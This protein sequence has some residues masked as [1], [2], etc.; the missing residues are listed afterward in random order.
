[1]IF[2]AT[3]ILLHV[4]AAAVS[5]SSD[6]EEIIL[7]IAEASSTHHIVLSSTS[8]LGGRVSM[9]AVRKNVFVIIFFLLYV[10]YNLMKPIWS[11]LVRG[12]PLWCF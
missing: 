10:G 9:S 4:L 3:C 5:Y 12:P 6:I 7:K 8:G 11:K 2:T 1:M